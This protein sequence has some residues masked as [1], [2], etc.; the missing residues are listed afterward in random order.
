MTHNGFKEHV[1]FLKHTVWSD[2]LSAAAASL[3]AAP[4]TSITHSLLPVLLSQQLNNMGATHSHTLLVIFCPQLSNLRYPGISPYL[5]HPVE[6]SPLGI[7]PALVSHSRW[8]RWFLLP[9]YEFC[10]CCCVHFWC[11][12]QLIISLIFT[13]PPFSILPTFF[14]APPCFVLHL[15]FFA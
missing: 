7:Q 5:W 13:P 12:P 9:C 8:S 10:S 11:Q 2:R 14:S 1:F 4:W 3:A 15:W 6:D